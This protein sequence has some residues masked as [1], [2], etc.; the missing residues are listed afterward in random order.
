[1]I[2][3]VLLYVGCFA[4][5]AL[6]LTADAAWSGLELSPFEAAAA[7]ATTLANT[8][9]SFGFAGPM[10]SFEPF[11]VASKIV[12]T[13]LMLLGRIEILPFAV[14]LTRAYWRP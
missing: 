7:A 14:L 12:M 6:A 2:V 13:A 10:G 8:G 11:G 9:P 1:M 4:L 3:F 5:G